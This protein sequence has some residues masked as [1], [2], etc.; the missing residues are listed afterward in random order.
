[1]WSTEVYFNA[2]KKLKWLRRVGVLWD[3]RRRR[4]LLMVF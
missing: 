1:M 2:R 4:M 3:G